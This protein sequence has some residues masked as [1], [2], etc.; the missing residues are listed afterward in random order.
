MMHK[1]PDKKIDNILYVCAFIIDNFKF[2][3]YNGQATLKYNS[4]FCPLMGQSSAVR[5]NTINRGYRYGNA[6]DVQS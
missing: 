5:R 6:T 1:S 3:Y 2:K 4:E